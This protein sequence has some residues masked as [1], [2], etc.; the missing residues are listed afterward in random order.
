M[1]VPVESYPNFA[2]FCNERVKKTINLCCVVFSGYKK[3]TLCHP[4]Q[5]DNTFEVYTRHYVRPFG[6][7]I[8]YTEIYRYTIQPGG[9]SI[10]SFGV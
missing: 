10:F 9:D 5:V 2:S 7:N 8:Q 4:R 6:Q 3:I 1:N